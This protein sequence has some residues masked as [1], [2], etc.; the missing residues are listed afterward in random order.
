MKK[1]KSEKKHAALKDAMHL[2]TCNIALDVMMF[3]IVVGSVKG[4]IGQGKKEI[5]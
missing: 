1:Q 5:K 3:Y 4:T 2:K